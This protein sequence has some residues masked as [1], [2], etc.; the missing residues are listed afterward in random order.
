MIFR[1]GLAL[2]IIGTVFG[3]TGGLIL[4]RFLA[5]YLYETRSLDP[6]IFIAGSLW[7]VGITLL[8]GYLP[9]KR[10]ARLDP[11]DVLRYE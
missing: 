2:S 1:Q 10:A 9:A 4:T 3:V 5:N 8:A 7:V 11:M 6:V